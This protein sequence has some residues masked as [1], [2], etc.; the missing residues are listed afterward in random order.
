MP[1]FPLFFESTP[2]LCLLLFWFSITPA[3]GLAGSQTIRLY[4][5]ELLSRDSRA[6]TVPNGDEASGASTFSKLCAD[7]GLLKRPEGLKDGDAVDGFTDEATLLRFLQANDMDSTK[8]LEQLKQAT[9]FRAKNDAFRIYDRI[10]VPDYEDTRA[11]YPHWTGRC[12]REGRPILMMDVSALGKE[13]MGEWRKTKQ[14]PQAT[15]SG[16]DADPEISPN[17]P[18]RALA[19]FDYFTRFVLPLCSAVQGKP[20]TSCA[21]VVDA[22]PLYMKQAWEL[23]E[24]A[25]DISWIL[26]TCFP[27]TI[28]RIYCCNVPGFLARCWAFL[29]SFVNPVTASK[30]QFLTKDNAY[31][32]LRETIEHDNIP[33][34]IGGGFQFETGMLPDLDDQIRR[35]L[36][37]SGS[38]VDLPPGPIKW[39]QT[40]GGDRK[41]IAT[42]TDAEQRAVEVATLRAPSSEKYP[43][44]R[45]VEE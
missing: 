10:S 7:A 11:L 39:I 43:E 17:M 30:I 33:T 19:H 22:G 44:D 37:W 34:S 35:A 40:A 25:N 9:D 20:V 21:Y 36:E 42:G 6:M 45:I 8:A 24:F 18:Q 27:E 15:L 4:L 16:P 12:D 2:V 1:N 13:G 26:A 32:T 29:K 5:V 3:Y 31:D 14:I 28:Y 23:R 41:A 38:H